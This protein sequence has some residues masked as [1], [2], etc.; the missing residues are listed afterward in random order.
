MSVLSIVLVVAAVLL[1]LAVLGV[2]AWLFT[3]QNRA[4]TAAVAELRTQ[5][6]SGEQERENR[7]LTALEGVRATLSAR[8]QI[9]D[10]TR[11]SI[12]RLER[13]LVGSAARGAAGEN[14]VEQSLRNLPNEL[15]ER[16]FWVNGKVVEFALRLPDGKKLAIDSKWSSG[17]VLESL[18][19]PDLDPAEAVR[20]TNQLEKEVERKVR[21]VAQY[22][23]HSTTASFAIAAV[24]DAV[25]AVC[26]KVFSVAQSRNVMIISYSLT[27]PYLLSLYQLYLQFGRNLDTGN[28]EAALLEIDRY[29]NEID[30]SLENKLQRALTMVQNS[31]SETKQAVARI[32]SAAISIHVTTPE[33]L[34]VPS[35]PAL[36]E[37]LPPPAG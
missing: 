22:L 15:V 36:G 13:A 27:L 5:A 31:Y 4:F 12:Q 33:A 20:L 28:L 7:A 25:Y 30:S 3:K 11:T 34:I 1:V 24:P 10:E 6:T 19:A 8:L 18:A 9:E 23:D 21:E 37:P 17:G 35:L 26:R 14:I 32:R 29:L 2:I 16:D